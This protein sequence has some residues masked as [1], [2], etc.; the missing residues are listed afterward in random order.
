MSDELVTYDDVARW[1]PDDLR[2]RIA[3]TAPCRDG[4][5][6]RWEHRAYKFS[7]IGRADP[8]TQEWWQCDR[9]RT[10]IKTDPASSGQTEAGR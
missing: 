6:H 9:C 1:L 3:A 4:G 7:T 2:D 10:V 5:A 8:I